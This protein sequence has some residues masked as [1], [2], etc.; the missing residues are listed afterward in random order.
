MKPE[1]S[2][3]KCDNYDRDLVYKTLKKSVNI[4]GGMGSF[5]KK[6]ETVLL[7]PNLLFAKEPEKA[8]TTHPSVLDAVLK[9]V[10]EAGGRPLV[11]DS[12]GI[13]NAVKVASKAGIKEVC[14]RLNVSIID[15]KESVKVENPKGR[16]FKNFTIAK[17]VLDVDC[18]INLPKL[19]THAQ[20][21]LTLGVKNLFGCIAGRRKSQWHFAAGRDRDNFARMLVDLYYLLKPRLTIVDGILAMEGNGPGSGDPKELGLIFAS[22][23]CIALDRVITEVLG[24]KAYDLFTTKVANEDGMGVTSLEEI[25]VQGENLSNITVRG[26]K[27]PPL[28]NVDY[29]LPLPAFFA[30]YFRESFTPK[31]SIHNKTCTMCKICVDVCPADIMSLKDGTIDIDYESC[32]R[33]YCCQEV[34]PEGAITVKQGWLGRLLT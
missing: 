5:I 15:F 8:V 25:E 30:H 34:C 4:L 17:E 22:S 31:P 11:G 7:K 6:G 18:I 32:I 2:I 10:I 23:D 20:M 12:P 3:L 1:V 13:G 19:K 33:C 14:D 26:F 29:F 28:I 9:L 24:A 16:T 27:F 21:F